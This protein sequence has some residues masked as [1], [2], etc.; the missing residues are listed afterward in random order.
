M[1]YSLIQRLSC[2]FRRTGPFKIPACDQWRQEVQAHCERRIQCCF[3]LSQR[4]TFPSSS[5]QPS[6]FA[7]DPSREHCSPPHHLDLFPQTTKLSDRQVVSNSYIQSNHSPSCSTNLLPAR[8]VSRTLRSFLHPTGSPRHSTARRSHWHVQSP[9]PMQ[10]L[11]YFEWNASTP[12]V[13]L[14]MSPTS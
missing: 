4:H 5:M 3:R 10:M 9:R 11:G 1:V 13:N 6:C 12:F 14:D 8:T 7:R 2:S